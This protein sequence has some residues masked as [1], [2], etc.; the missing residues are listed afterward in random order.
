MRS[1]L[2]FDA[3]WD[4]VTFLACHSL[5]H[6]CLKG[7]WPDAAHRVDVVRR[8]MK[9]KEPID[10]LT[11]AQLA[12]LAHEVADEIGTTQMM[13]P[14]A[15][16]A[17]GRCLLCARGNPDGARKLSEIREEAWTRLAAKRERGTLL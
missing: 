6:R 16:Q 10:W 8:C 17:L 2:P 5:I 13:D 1:P 3:Q 15:T 9:G 12:E 11:A 14:A 7:A 4:L